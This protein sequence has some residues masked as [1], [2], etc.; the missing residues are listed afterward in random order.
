MANKV[1]KSDYA[2]EAKTD[3]MTKPV[4]KDE[5]GKLWTAPGSGGGGIAVSGATVGQTV[6]IAAVDDDGVPTAWEPVDFPSGG[7]VAP[8]YRLIGAIV[9]SEPVAKLEFAIPDGI[10]DIVAHFFNKYDSELSDT[11]GYFAVNGKSV[12]I[13]QN[14]SLN[15]GLDQQIALHFTLLT[16]GKA[17]VSVSKGSQASNNLNMSGLSPCGWLKAWAGDYGDAI[18]KVSFSQVNPRKAFGAGCEMEVWGK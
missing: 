8:G 15:V 5:Y 10:T 12:I 11:Y 1:P 13:G 4:G 7:S 6:K 16:D 2:P 9:L 3:A 17:Y 18:T 14:M